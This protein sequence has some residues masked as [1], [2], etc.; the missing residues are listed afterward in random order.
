[1]LASQA[2]ASVVLFA[3]L[4]VPACGG[5]SS[6]VPTPSYAR[7]T[8]TLSGS[9]IAAHSSFCKDFNNAR[10]GAVSADVSPASI[11]LALG[12]GT[13]GAPGQILAEKDGEV[14]NVDAPAGW[15]HVTLSNRSDSNTPFTLRI[16]HWY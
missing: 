14:A 10:A 9:N 5:D 13:C 2:R 8:E 16:T 6:S 7:G 3:A 15:N 1:M 4:A 11:H 12:V